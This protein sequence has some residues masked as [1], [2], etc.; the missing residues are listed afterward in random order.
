M[1]TRGVETLA[2]KTFTKLCFHGPSLC[3]FGRN[4]AEKRIL[5]KFPIDFHGQTW[6]H[7]HKSLETKRFV[8]EREMKNSNSCKM[9]KEEE[10]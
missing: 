3:A 8:Q 10:Q 9:K 6:Y 4:A 2:W 5:R 7:A 1:C